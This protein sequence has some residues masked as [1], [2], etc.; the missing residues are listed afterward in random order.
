VT[1]VKRFLNNQQDRFA[2]RESLNN[3]ITINQDLQAENIQLKAT[4]SYYKQIAEIIDFKKRY[5][6]SEVIT[7]QV[8]LK[9]MNPQGHF[10]L[11]DKGAWHKV[12]KNMVAVY[13]NCLIG[14]VT[15]VYPLYSK[16][17]LI[18]DRSC[19]VAAHCTKTGASGIHVG[20]NSNESQALKRVSHLLS[21]VQGDLV[22]SS[23]KGAVFPQG[24]ALGKIKTIKPGGLYHH[25]SVEPMVQLSTIDYCVLLLKGINT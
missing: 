22:L 25:L 15:D 7:S 18:T 14:R 19:K 5:Q 2:L 17:I 4:D 1:P 6:S 11:I 10:F 16:L 20:C 8:M 24:F 23:G 3:L 12:K 21:V 9:Q 13:K